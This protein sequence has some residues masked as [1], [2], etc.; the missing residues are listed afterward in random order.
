MRIKIILVFIIIVYMRTSFSQ[1]ISPVPPTPNS[2][3]NQDLQNEFKNLTQ[4][5]NV[6]EKNQDY[7]KAAT[8]INDFNGNL[9]VSHSIPIR[10]IGQLNLSLDLTYNSNCNHTIFK[11]HV[12]SVKPRNVFA[13]AWIFSI[14]GI[15]I[16]TTNFE[17]NWNIS[18]QNNTI[19]PGVIQSDN[20]DNITPL[21]GDYIPLLLKGYHF[22]NTL[23][24][25][26]EVDP[27]KRDVITILKGDG[28]TIEL[29]NP[30]FGERN[31]SNT[32]LWWSNSDN[33]Y[34]K[35]GTYV[36]IGESNKGYAHVEWING[37]IQ[38]WWDRLRRIYY[39]PGNG[40][41]YCFEEEIAQYQDLSSEGNWGG[42]TLRAPRI[43]YL[44]SIS[45]TS[46]DKISFI[47]SDV[48]L[49]DGQNIH[50]YNGRKT[51]SNVL[52]TQ[53]YSSVNKTVIELSI[54]PKEDLEDDKIVMSINGKNYNHYLWRPGN[55]SLTN[56]NSRHGYNTYSG[57]FLISTIE[58]ASTIWNSVSYHYTSLSE[59]NYIY[60]NL[61]PNT[62][63]YDVLYKIKFPNI[64]LNYIAS[65][66]N[67]S[68]HFIRVYSYYETEMTGS[69]FNPNF[70][71]P[72]GEQKW[73]PFDPSSYY[74][75]RFLF[76]FYVGN[77]STCGRDNYSSNI[78]KES[79]ILIG[80]GS[81]STLLKK[82]VYEYS[83][84]QYV[85]KT[86]GN[87]PEKS[88]NELYLP[89]YYRYYDLKTKITTTGFSPDKGSVPTSKIIENYFDII[90][91]YSEVS[92]NS[93]DQYGDEIDFKDQQIKLMKT[94]SYSPN[95]TISLVKENTWDINAVNGSYYMGGTYEL[96][97]TT[98]SIQENS[99]EIMKSKSEFIKDSNPLQF[100]VGIYPNRPF[101]KKFNNWEEIKSLSEPI[102]N[103]TELNFNK[104]ISKKTELK[105]YIPIT[106]SDF[107]NIDS[108]YM[109]NLPKQNISKVNGVE[110]GHEVVD[111][112]DSPE[113]QI[114]KPNKIT[115]YGKENSL[116]SK[117]VLNFE[118]NIEQ[119]IYQGYLKKTWDDKGL[120][121]E[122]FYL[123]KPENSFNAKAYYEDGSSN[124][125]FNYTLNRDF[126]IEPFK[127]KITNGTKILEMFSVYDIN[128]NLIYYVDENDLL[129]NFEY[130]NQNRLTY[131]FLPGDL[132]KNNFDPE[133]LTKGSTVT[134]Y[135]RYYLPD[136]YKYSNCDLLDN[137]TAINETAKKIDF[138]NIAIVDEVMYDNSIVQ[139][140]NYLNYL[141]LF[142]HQID[143]E[144]L[145]KGFYFNA[146]GEVNKV[147]Y[148][149]DNG[150]TLALEKNDYTFNNYNNQNYDRHWYKKIK[151]TDASSNQIKELYY[152]YEGK[153]IKETVV[154]INNNIQYNYN[155]LDQLD[156][157]ISREAKAV[158]YLYD[159]L[160]NIK[161]K[162]SNDF[163]IYQYAY[164]NKNRLRFS[165]SKSTSPYNVVF[166]RY[167]ALD[168]ILA[169]GSFTG[170]QHIFD[171]DDLDPDHI[172]DANYGGVTAFEN[173]NN[174]I[175]NFLVVN[176]Y[177]DYSKDGVFSSMSDPT[178][179]Q[180]I[181]N[182]NLIG[183]KVMTAFRDNQSAS[184]NYKVFGYDKWGNISDSWI[185]FENK[186]WIH[187]G[188][189][190]N[191][192]G[193]LLKISLDNM[194]FWY[195]YDKQGRLASV[196]SNTTNNISTSNLEVSYSYN[197]VDQIIRIGAEEKILDNL[198]I[199]GTQSF[200]GAD[201]IAKNVTV[202][203]NANLTLKGGSSVD[204]M[205]GFHTNL[206][207]QLHVLIDP[208]LG[209]S[210]VQ[211]TTKYDYD[212]RGRLDLI[213]H[214][215]KGDNLF[216]ETLTY[217]NNGN[218]NTQTIHNFGDGS[219]NNLSFTYGYDVM[220]RLLSS[221]CNN[222]N[223]DENFTYDKDGNFL[224]K[225]R[226]NTNYTYAYFSNTNKLNTIS[227]IYSFL[228]D[229]KGNL[230]Q[231]NSGGT[232][233]F[234]VTNYDYRNLPLTV[235][236]ITF[237]TTT[238]K[239]D[240]AGNR[241]YKENGSLK[242]FYLRDNSGNEIVIY[243]LNTNSVK[244]FNIIGNGL[245]G[246]IKLGSPDERFYFVKDHLGSVRASV[247]ENGEIIS[248]KDYFAYG[249][250]LRNINYGEED[251][252]DFTEKERD[253]ETGLNYFGARYL[254]SDLGRWLSV[255]PLADKYP[256]WSPYNYV[257]NN[258]LNIIDPN[259]DSTFVL[260]NG[261]GTYTVNGGKLSGTDD[262]TG[263]YIKNADGTV[264]HVGNSLTTHSFFG[265]DGNAVIGAVIN[266]SSTEG[267]NFLVNEILIKNPS[268]AE[269]I[270]NARN[271]NH[272]D[273]KAHGVES[274][275]AG[276]TEDQYFYRGSVSGGGKIG[277]ARDFGNI[278]A[279]IVAGRN[280]LPWGVARI[281]FDGYQSYRSGKITTEGITTQKAQRI[282]HN[283]GIILRGRVIR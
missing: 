241:I 7:I 52:Y 283:I 124:L 111:Y 100:T 248:A 66:P 255:D 157:V 257:M 112:N 30:T 14:G 114:G 231:K 252:Y 50:V 82:D 253:V 249:N 88:F 238:Y 158:G 41:T 102:L 153:I 203:S 214:L 29:I 178:S 179:P 250:V 247:D 49:D 143:A 99:S 73:D 182:L 54:I 152:N 184:W 220:N 138:E 31:P 28:S 146:L 217:E 74:Y 236:D 234:T 95:E 205:P 83:W 276:M 70:Y 226:N 46:G 271:T 87:G 277:S 123:N 23:Q 75:G 5:S 230:T 200:E 89:W 96:L 84:D 19:S 164:D 188:Y 151:S 145:Q 33:E 47:Y 196:R 175:N 48:L 223:Y 119:D 227:G 141:G 147:E 265:D 78:I 62:S 219:W 186:P 37:S 229:N 58:D 130:D 208:A 225:N 26:S 201:V 94:I 133:V 86:V 173:L 22:S 2:Y 263:V 53:N 42:L 163:G 129:Y 137:T 221:N 35:I 262:D 118:Y 122:F 279:G 125:N 194:Y 6:Q 11:G 56:D 183:K 235:T 190:Y 245:V 20:I 3:T 259:G 232:N 148:F 67:F 162:T 195:A 32:E 170:N 64:C 106:S 104:E 131:S 72:L 59:R 281:G 81:S 150:T 71:I 127:V 260:K 198:T 149:D 140:F 211:G 126:Q 172:Y 13:P 222:N 24:I 57:I 39:K 108:Y 202:N 117:S 187:I 243:D 8:N 116:R 68:E 185:K 189:I 109:I 213:N 61:I 177:D 240:D 134:S 244:Q 264:T 12:N 251:R 272:F 275:P 282:G 139:N 154:G 216:E 166:N 228:Y 197:N 156:E 107:N 269:Y 237:G 97:S 34:S 17:K 76:H 176:H 43:L 91:L 80:S 128:S 206:G 98:E 233:I 274:R 267:Q 90:K 212:N 60:Y 261:N 167:D 199:S 207:G 169:I 142:Q 92:F 192:I 136:I 63:D 224:T 51:L 165:M 246:Y 38:N 105:H 40:L 132:W 55:Y 174:N 160:G 204:L 9:V 278:G 171:N 121:K 110:I 239:Y 85:E 79:K 69:N 1:N 93:Q 266:I 4:M 215:S 18:T 193:Q 27:I 21:I 10:E 270:P 65:E 120:V 103:N 273:F 15:A 45:N 161:E 210:L 209:E 242:D 36:E 254:D 155:T 144:N 256:G 77:M 191:S 101:V 258:P 168:R 135:Y 113:Y 180:T 16:Q 268:L 115:K 218:I 159:D 280:Y 181:T 44:K 25:D